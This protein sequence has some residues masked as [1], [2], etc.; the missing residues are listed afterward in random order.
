MASG[1]HFHYRFIR[2]RALPG[3][4]LGNWPPEATFTMNLFVDG[5]Q[6]NPP[7]TARVHGPTASR[8]HGSRAP[9]VD[10]SAGAPLELRRG[11]AIPR[12]TAPRV[13][14]PTGPPLLI[15]RISLSWESLLWWANQNK[16]SLLW[17]PD[18]KK[19][20]LYDGG[21]TITGGTCPGSPFKSGRLASRTT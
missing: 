5:R 7:S 2:G 21:P 12:S 4:P 9:W 20:N 6:F 14:G 13:H 17:W 1:G 10:G 11:V 19:I 18:R 8:A 15:S 16:E 3:P